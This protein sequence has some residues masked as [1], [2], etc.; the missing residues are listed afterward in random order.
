MQPIEELRYLILAAQRE[1]NRQ[2]AEALRPLPLT[3]AQAEALRVL[4]DHEPL[5]LIALGDLLVCETGSPSRLVQGLVEDGLV[6]RSPSATDKRMVTLTLTDLG[7]ERAENVAA[8]ESQFYEAYA[9]LV[10]DAP[11]PEILKVLRRFVE[12]KP[13]GMALARRIG[14]ETE[15][16][17]PAR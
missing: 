7:R 4:Q 10:Q 9:D 1:G 6:E 12:D 13:A 5:S 17:R 3:P 11:L 2:L 15:S 16:K 8:I 14:R